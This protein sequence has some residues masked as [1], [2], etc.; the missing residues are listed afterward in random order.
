MFGASRRRRHHPNSAEPSQ[1]AIVI[2]VHRGRQHR[3]EAA[4]R[5]P[6]RKDAVASL[7]RYDREDAMATIRSDR[8]ALGALTIDFVRNRR[9]A[10]HRAVL[11]GFATGLVK[12][13]E[14]WQY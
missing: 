2:P 14:F 12:P 4:V 3:A 1:L 11:T 8:D 7:I 9:R 6:L 10:A 5:R 13:L